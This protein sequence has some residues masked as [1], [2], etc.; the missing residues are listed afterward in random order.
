MWLRKWGCGVRQLPLCDDE[1]TP[2][3]PCQLCTSLYVWFCAAHGLEAQVLF[4]AS[5]TTHDISFGDTVLPVWCLDATMAQS[6][7]DPPHPALHQ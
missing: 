4:G 2:G 6:H 5:A 7:L 3:G 1:V